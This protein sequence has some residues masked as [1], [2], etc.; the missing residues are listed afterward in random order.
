[1]VSSGGPVFDV[2]FFLHWIQ[3]HEDNSWGIFINDHIE[4]AEGHINS[5]EALVRFT[6]FFTG[7]LWRI[8]SWYLTTWRQLRCIEDFWKQFDND[9]IA[10]PREWCMYETLFVQERV[11][12]CSVS[13]R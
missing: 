5:E 7:R 3:R 13:L 4:H 9:A 2:D 1:M 6:T 12:F 10:H 8:L 11:R